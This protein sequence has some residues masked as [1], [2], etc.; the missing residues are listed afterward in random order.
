MRALDP[1]KLDDLSE[2]VRERLSTVEEFK[3]ARIMACYVSKSDEVGTEEILRSAIRGGVKVLVPLTDAANGKL[4]FS[5][6]RDY[7]SELFPGVF[8]IMEPKSEY[9]RPVPLEDADLALVPIVAWDERGYRIG[10]GKGYFDKALAGLSK[11]ET[12]GLALEAQRVDR[13][14]ERPYDVPLQLITTERR[15]L[16]F[17]RPQR[18]GR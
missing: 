17:D 12:I 13:V 6:L 1:R 11:T 3:R 10:H 5:E 9:L 7:D 15:V 18:P 14:P 4:I 2:Q 16:R 8:G